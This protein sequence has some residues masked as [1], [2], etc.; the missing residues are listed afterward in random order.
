MK[1]RGT[2][3]SGLAVP[4]VAKAPKHAWIQ[5]ARVQGIRRAIAVAVGEKHSIA[6]QGL[7]LPQLPDN[8]DL[9]QLNTPVVRPS[10]GDASSSSSSTSE[11]CV[12]RSPVRMGSLVRS[13]GLQSY[14]LSP[15][16]PGHM[17]PA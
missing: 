7:W 5:P 17:S 10:G 9:R 3:S 4:D 13:H 15:I 14:G 1:L 2:S 11:E 6:L 12:Q 16:M 8:L